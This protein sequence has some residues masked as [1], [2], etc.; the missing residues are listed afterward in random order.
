MDV[1]G[2]R[3]GDIGRRSKGGNLL[4]FGGGGREGGT[5][6]MVVGG[7]VG[8]VV[9]EVRHRQVEVLIVGVEGREI[10]FVLLEASFDGRMDVGIEVCDVGHDGAVGVGL[11]LALGIELV[12]QLIDPGRQR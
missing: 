1:V 8:R 5:G 9:G 11:N 3:L 6:K 12:C 10:E 4:E 2:R 7:G